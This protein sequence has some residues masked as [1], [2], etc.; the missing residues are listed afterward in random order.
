MCAT[1]IHKSNEQKL[2]NENT[3][4]N[5]ITEMYMRKQYKQTY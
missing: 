3:E 5:Y 1:L 4:Q 2:I